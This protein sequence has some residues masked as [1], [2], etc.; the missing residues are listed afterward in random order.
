MSEEQQQAI[1]EKFGIM[2]VEGHPLTPYNQ[3]FLVSQ[4]EINFTIIGGFQQWKK[5]GRVVRK[6]E[7]GSLIL[8]PSK[9]K[10]EEDSDILQDD[11][12]V[13]FF[14]ATVFDITQTLEIAKSETS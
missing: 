11:E 10:V 6:G 7:H 14:S 8:V 9:P 5:A 3:C 12:D 2:T 4:S 1:A 13:R